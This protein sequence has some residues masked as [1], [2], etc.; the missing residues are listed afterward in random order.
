MRIV[1]RSIVGIL[2]VSSLLVY[3]WSFTFVVCGDS[4]SNN[5]P[6]PVSEK[7]GVV[8][9]KI[10]ASGAKFVIHTGDF[11]V[12]A[13][14]RY[15]AR[16]QADIFMLINKALRI[17]FYPVM[18]NHEAQGDGW[19]V[20]KEV[21]FNG[22]TTYYSFAYENS[23]FIIL[24]AHQPGNEYKFATE[25][26]QW[27]TERIKEYRKGKYKHLFVFA[28]PPIF[29]LSHVG[30]SLDRYSDVQNWLCKT[31][32]DAGVD[33]Y[34]CG[35]DHFY[36]R[37]YYKGVFQ[38]IS[39]GAGAPMYKPHEKEVLEY[40][41]E[42]VKYFK[43]EVVEHWIKVDVIEDKVVCVVYNLE[44]KIIDKFSIVKKKEGMGLISEEK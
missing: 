28:H 10:N 32:S 31:L 42:K 25:Q 26:V 2:F 24:D 5:N 44:D 6:A 27:L 16:R 18:G 19:E 23:Y 3:G 34:F 39:G 20:C 29:P 14:N 13:P 40:S 8:I 17:P 12:G 43:V 30:S 33:A 15:E 38:V 9:N 7:Y 21:L 35:H 41:W 11:Y 37:M 4:R 36:S 22:A 1:V